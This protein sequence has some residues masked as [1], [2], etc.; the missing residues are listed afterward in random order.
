A[1]AKQIV[2]AALEGEAFL[3]V[4]VA[5]GV[6]LWSSDGSAMQ[7]LASKFGTIDPDAAVSALK[8]GDREREKRG[9]Y[10]SAMFY[11]AGEWY[12]GVDR[13]GYLE[14]R[15]TQLGA[16]RSEV[17]AG[18]IVNRGEHGEHGERA[19]DTESCQ[20]ITLEVFFSARSPYS[21]I[22]LEPVMDLARRLP[23]D[24]VVRPVL[25]MVMRGLAVPRS[26]KFYIL[27]DAKREADRLGV[28]FGHV[29]DP[30]GRPVERLYSLVPFARSRGRDKELLLAFTRAAWAEG[31]D[32]G[33]DAG[34]KT[35]VERAG[36]HFDEAR[37]HLDQDNGWRSEVETNRADLLDLGLWGVPCFRI[38]G[39]GEESDFVS[40]GQD[41]LWLVEAAIRE[42]LQ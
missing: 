35:V 13:L 33:S 31:V 18:P 1:L 29:C 42:R 24:V 38:R 16:C 20:R 23:I 32:T 10:F 6:A 12:W 39:D 27:T 17:D 19:V 36:L 15:L 37:A 30:L 25:P 11:Y 4:I 41:R 21:Y 28:P 40:W 34:I 22:V 26:K 8:Q 5:V 14:Q 2:A 9:H 3:D 7:E